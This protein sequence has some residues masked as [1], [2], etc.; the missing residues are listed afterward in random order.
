[1]LKI[2]VFGIRMSTESVN[3]EFTSRSRASA[4]DLTDLATCALVIEGAKGDGR[5]EDGDV[6]EDGCGHVLQQGFVTANY[7]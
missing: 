1:M 6:E 3:G 4:R 7:T 2:K 5:E